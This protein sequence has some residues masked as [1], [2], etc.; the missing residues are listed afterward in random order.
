MTVTK[1]SVVEKIASY[2]RH[3]ISLAQLV[4]WAENIMLDGEL[5]ESD[6]DVLT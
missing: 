4:D 6:A 2:L 3:E 1:Q 5:S